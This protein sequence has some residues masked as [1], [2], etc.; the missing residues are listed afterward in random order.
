MAIDPKK[1]KKED[2]E[3]EVDP[4]DNWTA[5]EPIPDEEG[6]AAAKRKAIVDLRAAHLT[7]EMSKK[8]KKKSGGLW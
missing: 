2:E 5:S 1:K 4:F 3:E 8:K 6:E 7:Q